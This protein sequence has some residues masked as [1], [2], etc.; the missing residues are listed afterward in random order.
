VGLEGT[1]C[2]MKAF[3]VI[4]F[5][6]LVCEVLKEVSIDPVEHL[7]FAEIDQFVEEKNRGNVWVSF[8]TLFTAS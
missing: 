2:V 5:V 3:V 7:E 6:E 8:R 4:G 1:T